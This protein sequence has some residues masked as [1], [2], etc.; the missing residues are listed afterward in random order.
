MRAK[1][2][3]GQACGQTPRSGGGEDCCKTGSIRTHD[4]DVTKGKT[5]KETH[6]GRPKKFSKK[7][8]RRETE[9]GQDGGDVIRGG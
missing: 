3:S 1:V 9:M 7:N 8:G 2:G 4:R 6:Q 5:G